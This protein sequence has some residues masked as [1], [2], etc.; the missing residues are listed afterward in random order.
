MTKKNSPITNDGTQG[1]HRNSHQT[2]KD[3]IFL[4]SGVTTLST[5]R[6][7]AGN[8]LSRDTI[9]CQLMKMPVGI[10]FSCAGN[11]EVQTSSEKNH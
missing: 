1:P 5:P 4:N 2:K 7:T 10:V 11:G 3:N 6:V 9:E 8:Q